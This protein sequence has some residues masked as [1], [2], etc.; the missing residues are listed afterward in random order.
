MSGTEISFN[1]VPDQ[2]IAEMKKHVNKLHERVGEADELL[3][4]S[5]VVSNKVAVMKEVSVQF[6][7]Q[8]LDIFSAFP[9]LFHEIIFPLSVQGRN[10]HVQLLLP[11]QGPLGPDP[12]PAAREPADPGAAGGEPAAEAGPGGHAK[13]HGADHGEAPERGA[14][15]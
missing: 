5:Y 2:L 8:A 14:Q 4:H 1:D 10:R 9:P 12:R 6:L 11:R 15:L 13:G 7:F 3:Q